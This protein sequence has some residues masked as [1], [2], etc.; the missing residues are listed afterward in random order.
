MRAKVS[1]VLEMVRGWFRRETSDPATHLID[2]A[3]D[4]FKLSD[5]E[6][7]RRIRELTW[8]MEVEERMPK[9]PDAHGQQDQRP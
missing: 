2:E 1:R 3:I 8:R 6:L 5:R 9:R 4:K 7:D